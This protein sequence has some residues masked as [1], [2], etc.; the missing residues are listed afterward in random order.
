MFTSLFFSHYCGC[1]SYIA[2]RLQPAF[3]G[4]FLF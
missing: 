4:L 2:H 1:N 3:A